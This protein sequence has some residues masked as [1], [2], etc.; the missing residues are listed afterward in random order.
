MAAEL[1]ESRFGPAAATLEFDYDGDRALGRRGL[2]PPLPR[3]SV[4]V[5]A[6]DEAANISEVLPYLSSFFE[7]IVVV[8]ENDHEPPWRRCHRRG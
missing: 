6:K 4:V 8:S 5:P 1:A 7:V 2:R 3:V